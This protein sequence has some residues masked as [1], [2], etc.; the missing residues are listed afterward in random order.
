MLVPSLVLL[1]AFAVVPHVLSN[2]RAV[3]SAA[4]T[5]APAVADDALPAVPSSVP[6][7]LAWDRDIESGRV[8]D[9]AAGARGPVV[10]DEDTVR[11]LDP[12]DG[13]TLW[14]YG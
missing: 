14:S 2:Q 3:L 9:V 1:C 7:S 5:T 8:L 6:T 12:Q 10:L 4:Q 11:G 13:S